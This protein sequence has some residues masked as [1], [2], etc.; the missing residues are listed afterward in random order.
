V[1]VRDRLTSSS[2]I[3]RALLGL[4]SMA[5]PAL[6]DH[7]ASGGEPT[8]ATAQGE[9]T[10]VLKREGFDPLK[11]PIQLCT[12]PIKK[13][14]GRSVIEI[15]TE[16]LKGE[17][18]NLL[19]DHLRSL[20]RSNLNQDV[21]DRVVV[22]IRDLSHTLEGCSLTH[23]SKKE[24]GPLAGDPSPNR[25]LLVKLSD[26]AHLFP[27]SQMRGRGEKG[28]DQGGAD[29]KVL[30]E[31]L[32]KVLAV[33]LARLKRLEVDPSR[34]IAD[35]TI[36]TF[37]IE[38]LREQSGG[39]LA[40]AVLER[41]MRRGYFEDAQRF[42]ESSPK[43]PDA[44]LNVG[45][46]IFTTL[47]FSRREGEKDI[48]PTLVS[49]MEV[50]TKLPRK[51]HFLGGAYLQSIMVSDSESIDGVKIHAEAL[52]RYIHGLLEAG[53]REPENGVFAICCVEG[54]LRLYPEL[55]EDLLKVYRATGFLRIDRLQSEP[56]PGENR[57]FQV[58]RGAVGARVRELAAFV[59]D[60][61]FRAH[62]RIASLVFVGR[63]EKVCAG[64]IVE[65]L[66]ENGYMIVPSSAKSNEEIAE[67]CARTK[68]LAGRPS[69]LVVVVGDFRGL[70]LPSDLGNGVAPSAQFLFVGERLGESG[71]LSARSANL[72]TGRDSFGSSAGAHGAEL[73]FDSDYRLAG[74]KFLRRAFPQVSLPGERSEASPGVETVRYPA[75]K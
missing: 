54:G 70:E 71:G 15:E 66:E 2:I 56:Q 6:P 32:E 44:L 1:L 74:V 4:A 10:S 50:A 20:R 37:P 61:T 5:G 33:N 9:S 65:Q 62:S 24:E 48:V 29:S 31:A 22:H 53:E 34:Q 18:D 30:I 42:F 64:P 73:Q 72:L 38:S 59:E 16:M 17:S 63:E 69:D 75:R 52:E 19:R 27:R 67:A 39:I 35:S 58:Q 57:D 23:M 68:S 40:T 41:A 21:I 28:V 12:K 49:C 36:L 11:E 14:S 13:L 25:L 60:P 51:E 47:H 7:S 26:I 45:L 55:A 8:P 46:N 3:G 43:A